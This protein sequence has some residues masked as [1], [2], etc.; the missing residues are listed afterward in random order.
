M[1]EHPAGHIWQSKLRKRKCAPGKF[2]QILCTVHCMLSQMLSK[3]QNKPPN[4]I[5]CQAWSTVRIEKTA[6]G[7]QTWQLLCMGPW[8]HAGYDRFKNDPAR[9]STTQIFTLLK[10]MF[11][12]DL[13]DNA[14]FTQSYSYCTPACTDT[15]TCTMPRSWTLAQ[16]KPIQRIKP[17]TIHTQE[18]RTLPEIHVHEVSA[19]HIGR[20]TNVLVQC[21][22]WWSTA[23]MQR[24]QIPDQVY[25][26]RW[27]TSYPSPGKSEVFFL[28]VIHQDPAPLPCP[29]ITKHNRYPSWPFS[30]ILAS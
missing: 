19:R 20:D 11:G 27:V 26:S 15:R 7:S 17:S 9:W 22:Y 8:K 18:P 5:P 29:L 23:N 3:S 14:S 10:L 24:W 16:W 13:Y 6:F 12:R 1:T 28:L 25:Y 30:T 2:P 4:D 21:R